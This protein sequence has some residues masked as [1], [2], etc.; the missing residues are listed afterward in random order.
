MNH[1]TLRIAAA[2]CLIA[3]GATHALGQAQQP[4][5]SPKDDPKQPQSVPA[6][7][8]EQAPSSPMPSTL[9]TDPHIHTVELLRRDASM[10]LGSTMSPSVRQY[11]F[12]TNWLPFIE[13]PREVYYK[14]ETREAATPEEFAALPKDKAEGFELV[15]LDSKFYYH[16]RYGSPHAYARPLDLLCQAMSADGLCFGPGKK[17]FDFGCGGVIPLRLLAS[18]GVHAVGVDPDPLLRAYFRDPADVGPVGGSE[19]GV[20]GQLQFQSGYWPTDAAVKA[21]VGRDFDAIISKNTLKK[22]YVNPEKP[23]DPRTQVKLGVT[24]EAFVAELF[25]ALKPGGV[26]VI[27]NICGGQSEE[28]YNP[29]ADGRNPFPRALWE[30][31]GF[32]VL[33]YDTVDNAGVRV[34]GKALGWDVGSEPMDMEKD[35]F[36]WYSI[37]KKPEAVAP[38]DPAKGGDAKPVTSGTSVPP[39]P[40]K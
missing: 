14:R 8:Q 37:V 35:L 10:L 31:A 13:E 11:L 18:M 25:D 21:A 9:I 24:D 38:N 39:A 6:P 15:S 19:E 5:A 1:F 30:K 40:K 17:V 29:S 26:M 33:N 4:P 23:V 7:T 34:L 16:T 22:G 2:L 36:A 12:S 3:P 27:Y 20:L 32:T 28:V